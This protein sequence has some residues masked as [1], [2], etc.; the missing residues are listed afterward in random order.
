[1]WDG[2]GRGRGGMEK[3]IECSLQICRRV[4]PVVKSSFCRTAIIM[5][6]CGRQHIL[7]LGR[8]TSIER[9]GGAEEEVK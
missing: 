4:F 2:I 5:L 1:M 3:Y 7:S 6:I 9:D 8:Q